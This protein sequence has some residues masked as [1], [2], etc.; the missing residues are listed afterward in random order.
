LPIILK[1]SSTHFQLLKKKR[2]DNTLFLLT[3]NVHQLLN[4]AEPKRRSRVATGIHWQHLGAIVAN[5]MG[6]GKT[7]CPC[8]VPNSTPK[9]YYAKRRFSITSKC[10]QMH[11]VLNIDEIKN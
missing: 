3:C 1:G 2:P 6:L 11:G 4:K 10:R 8:L 5:D 7:L 9:F